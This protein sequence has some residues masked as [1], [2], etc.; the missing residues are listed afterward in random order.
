MPWWSR[1]A[2]P[3]PHAAPGLRRSPALAL[4][5]RPSPVLPPPLAPIR[6]ARQRLVIAAG[7]VVQHGT[8]ATLLADGGLYADLYHT[9]FIDDATAVP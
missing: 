2:R 9:Q 5:G 7:R 1:F 3:A 6:C 8:H 4:P